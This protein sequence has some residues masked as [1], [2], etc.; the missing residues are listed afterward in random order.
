MSAPNSGSRSSTSSSEFSCD[1]Q[2][3][4]SSA[5]HKSENQIRNPNPTPR[6]SLLVRFANPENPDSERPILDI[7]LLNSFVKS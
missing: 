1:T 7:V 4:D 3:L 6:T 2:N 5:V